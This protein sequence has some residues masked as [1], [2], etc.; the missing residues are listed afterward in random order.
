MTY[1][2][3]SPEE[4]RDI[5]FYVPS[6]EDPELNPARLKCAEKFKTNPWGCVKFSDR[7]TGKTRF[8]SIDSFT[9]TTPGRTNVVVYG[10]EETNGTYNPIALGILTH[11]AVRTISEVWEKDPS[12]VR[13][14]VKCLSTLY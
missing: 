7:K 9:S 5:E 1:V 3:L 4:L 14:L 11:D 10:F 6:M 2:V 13:F 8:L 12:S